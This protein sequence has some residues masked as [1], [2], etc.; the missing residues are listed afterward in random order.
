MAVTLAPTHLPHVQVITTGTLNVVTQVNLPTLTHLALTLHNRDK[1]T[2]ESMVSFD[3]S[4]TD[5]GAA[6]ASGAWTIDDYLN[7]NINGNGANG[8]ASITKLFLFSPSHNAVVIELMLQT[9]KPAN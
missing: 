6:P 9:A 2:K 4:L 3:Q 5:G 8:A 7:Y 1:A